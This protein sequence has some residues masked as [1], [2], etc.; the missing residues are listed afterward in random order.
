TL[1][2]VREGVVTQVPVTA[3]AVQGEWTVVYA[4]ELQAGDQVVGSVRA[5][6][7]SQQNEQ[8]TMMERSP[9]GGAPPNPFGGG[10]P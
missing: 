6:D 4:D 3:G 1:S 7:S 10:N 2:V 9:G 8:D 5:A